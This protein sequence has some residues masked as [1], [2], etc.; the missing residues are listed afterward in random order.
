MTQ[1]I[2]S[3]VVIQGLPMQTGGLYTIANDN[4]SFSIAKLL[5]FDMHGVHISIF[6]NFKA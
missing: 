2:S 5:A 6:S 1:G 4:G 3:K